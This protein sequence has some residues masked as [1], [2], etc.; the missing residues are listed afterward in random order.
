LNH[1]L[2]HH[3]LRGRAG[4]RTDAASRCTIAAIGRAVKRVSGAAS[5]H[6]LLWAGEE[7]GT[8]PAR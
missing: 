8:T 2:L 7:T 5:D 6:V 1:V 3:A 4:G